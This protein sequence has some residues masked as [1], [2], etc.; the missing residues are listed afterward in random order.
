MAYDR[1]IVD[2]RRVARGESAE[3][4]FKEDRFV[5]KLLDTLRNMVG[6]CM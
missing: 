4:G 1:L 3:M 6:E 5:R 2:G